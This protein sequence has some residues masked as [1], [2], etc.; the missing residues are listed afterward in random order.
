MNRKRLILALLYGAVGFI[1]GA[2]FVWL[3]HGDWSVSGNPLL[4]NVQA[5]LAFVGYGLAGAVPLALLGFGLSLLI[6]PRRLGVHLLVVFG[7]FGLLGGI[8]AVL[9]FIGIAMLWALL[10]IVIGMVGMVGTLI[11][12]LVP[13][14]LQDRRKASDVEARKQAAHE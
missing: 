9:H 3:W 5:Q 13:E 10:G 6:W 4:W 8:G 11:A 12:L 2:Y 1:P 14:S 7:L